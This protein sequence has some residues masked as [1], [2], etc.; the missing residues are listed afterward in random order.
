MPSAP[1]VKAA[2]P[3]LP[4]PRLG[5]LLS[6]AR[7]LQ[8]ASTLRE[9][10]EI[11]RVEVDAELGYA[12]VWLYVMAEGG[13]EV[14]IIDMAGPKRDVSWTLAPTIK[15]AGDAMME[16]ILRGDEPV[17]VEDARIDPR[18]NKELVAK[19]GNRTIVNVPLRLLDA[20]FG[21]LGT[22]TFGDEGCRVPTS[23]QLEYLVG[24]AGQLAVATGRIRF[25]EERQRAAEELE[26]SEE[27]LR[28]AQKM[29]AVGRLAGG[30]AHDFNNLLTVILSY[31]TL[32][33]DES[34]PRAS[35]REDLEMIKRA[36]ERAA[37]LTRQLLAFSRHQVSQPRVIDILEAIEASLPLLRSLVGEDVEFVTRFEGSEHFVQVDSAQLDQI[38]INL[39]VNA[40]DAMPRGGKLT[41]ELCK[42]TPN[43][44]TPEDPASMTTRPC[45]MLVVSDTGIGMDAE[46]RLRMFE[47]FF[48][49]KD[50]GK[51]TGL[52]LATVF[53]IMQ[54]SQGAISVESELGQGT[55]FELSFPEA[56]PEEEPEAVSTVLPIPAMLRQDHGSE[57][58]LVVDDQP[59]IRRVLRDILQRESYQ[60]LEAASA[61]DALALSERHS[62]RIDLLVT[63]VVMPGMQGPELAAELRAARPGLAVL[64]VS[65]YTERLIVADSTSDDGV[66]FLQKPIVPEALTKRVREMLRRER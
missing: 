31:S 5:R 18:T 44:S 42:V 34:Q 63:D 60:V 7:E 50:P 51:G 66:A 43:T 65:G 20:P 11:A 52:G 35:M 48:T 13:E 16:E 56:V 19:I 10:V 24:M 46:T 62:S 58:I 49:T 39:A 37:A 38:L 21:A 23:E 36:G 32:L 12:H 3:P 40:R 53:G 64:F 8:R 47:P 15:I 30:I 14:R 4:G 33:L 6:F 28:Q 41:I 26:K 25:Q 45:V 22:G 54:Q 17:V 55:R 57:T 9:L 29:E 59:D 27:R 1:P 61:A 2:S